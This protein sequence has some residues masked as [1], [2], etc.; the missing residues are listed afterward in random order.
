M[1]ESAAPLLDNFIKLGHAVSVESIILRSSKRD[2]FRSQLISGRST[3]IKVE[4]VFKRLCHGPVVEASPRATGRGP[5]E[6]RR[7]NQSESVKTVARL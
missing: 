5:A 2:P 1:K 3:A 7:E 4:H 6:Q